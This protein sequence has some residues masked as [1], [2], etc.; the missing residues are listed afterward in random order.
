MSTSTALHRTPFLLRLG[1]FVRFSHT[2]FALP[3]AL[4][5]F[6][7]ATSGKIPLPLLGWVLLC[8]VAAR[9]AAMC[10]NRLAD[11]EIDKKNP[12][13]VRRHTLIAKPIGWLIL[14]LSLTV[15]FLAASRINRL[16]LALSPLM[17]AVIFF[18]SLTKRFTAYS[19]FFLGLALCLAPIGAWM[20][21]TGEMR[22]LVPYLL[23]AAV[24]CW[25]FGFDLIYSTMDAEFD[26]AAGLFSFPS[27]YGIPAAL[28]LARALH[29]V[30]FF[31]FAAFGWLAHLGWAYT[32]ACAFTLYQLAV[33][34]RHAKNPD[35]SSINKAFFE[36]NA[37]VSLALLAGTCFDIFLLRS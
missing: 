18:Y 8:M 15:L 22:S 23:G 29:V 6:L 24:L 30:A 33:E 20:A 13:T 1:E 10:F 32:A 31:G 37:F 3:F 21:V 26:R 2:V 14:A 11:W 36:A 34:H 5:A 12:R 25:T 16:S 17:V 7:V 28:R 9:T 19:H 4:I 35:P 27:R